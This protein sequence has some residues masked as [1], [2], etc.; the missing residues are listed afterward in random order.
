M[1]CFEGALRA[2]RAAVLLGLLAGLPLAAFQP[3]AHPAAPATGPMYL[4]FAGG[5]GASFL[6]VSIAEVDAERASALKLPAEQGVEI[7]RVETDSPAEKAGLKVG[8]VVLEYNGERVVGMEQF[9]R[10]VRETP[11]GRKATLQVSR[12][13]GLQTLT[14][15]IASR[16]KYPSEGF[17]LVVPR[18][19]M[20]DIHMPDIPEGFPAWRSGMLGIET[21]SLNAQ[22][23]DF[24]GVKQGVLIRSVVSASPAEKAGIKAGDVL[25]KVDDQDVTTPGQVSAAIRAARNKHGVSLK[26]VRNR[27]EMTVTATLDDDHSAWPGAPES[28]FIRQ[29]V[30]K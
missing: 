4:A 29:E 27:H 22:L 18:F 6:G 11:A 19:E 7:T 14:A 15:V 23:A 25:T 1:S 16:G 24:F 2:P 5:A 17:S 21:E 20:P 10:M 28:G 9:G 8:D 30:R 3:Q 26:L 12:G 13:G